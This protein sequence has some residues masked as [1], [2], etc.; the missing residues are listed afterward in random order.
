M[1]TKLTL[2]IDEDLVKF[3]HSEARRRGTSVSDIF[4]KYLY[5][6]QLKASSSQRVPTFSEMRG[7]LAG[8]DIDDSKEGIRDAYAEKYLN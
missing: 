7:S 2:S 3:A 6:R 4:S 5:Q 1:K 8:L